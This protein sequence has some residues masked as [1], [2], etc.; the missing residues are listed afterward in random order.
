LDTLDILLSAF[1]KTPGIIPIPSEDVEEADPPGP[2]DPQDVPQL[3]FSVIAF[4]EQS[5][6]L[7]I[8]E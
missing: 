4:L 6:D 1:P 2:Q 5:S 7:L 3:D 8:A